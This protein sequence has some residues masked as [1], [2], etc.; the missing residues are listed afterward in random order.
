MGRCTA[1]THPD[2]SIARRE[3]NV[4]GYITKE[5]NPLGQ[6]TRK[7]YNFKGQP[8]AIYYPDGSEE[9][10]TY[11][12]HGPV[13][14]HTDNNESKTIYS[15]DVFDHPIKTETYS[16][17]GTLLKK[18]TATYSPFHKLSETDNKG[19][20]TWYSY[21]C[22]G[23]K[24]AEQKDC[25]E[26]SFTYDCLGRLEQTQE[27]EIS[28]IEKHDFLGQV[29]E[30]RTENNGVLQFQEKYVYDP[31]GNCTQTINSQ[32]SMPTIPSTAASGKKCLFKASKSN[33]TV[34]CG[35]ATMKWELWTKTESSKS[36]AFWE[37]D[38][39]AEIGAAVLYEI[40]GKTYVP[41][42][43]IQGSVITL[44]DLA[45]KK[46]IE[47]CRYTA[48]GETL[49]DHTLSPWCFA[50]KRLDE[51]GL[52]FFGR[53]YY[54]PELGRWI[55]P[56]PLGFKGG[57][58]LYA[59]VHNSPITEADLYGL[60]GIGN[61]LSR[62]AFRGLEWTGANL[63]PIP[64]LRGMVESVGRWGAGGDFSGPSRYRTGKS[65]IIPINGRIVPHH[66]YTH[67]NGMRTLKTD[68]RARGNIFPKPMEVFM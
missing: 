10:F 13:A 64:Y 25:A 11:F 54:C 14:S 41:L 52:I 23:R 39:G 49:T 33:M 21:D 47:C 46:T 18:T 37:K 63:L 5:I 35:T 15:L 16:P 4:L 67:G 60:L 55:T 43:D 58:N 6:E 2:G 9:H 48:Y 40:K 31:A 1:V 56:D 19:I 62:A 8:L 38:L 27:G 30:K 26:R 45:T 42:H 28:W 3:Y 51:T 59:Y 57:P 24:V 53:R 36:S 29:I 68:A 61:Y 65:E 7:T 44:I 12:A 20:I 17:S 32:G 50:S 66:S 22:A 34:I